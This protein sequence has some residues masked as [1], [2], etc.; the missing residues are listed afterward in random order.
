[1]EVRLNHYMLKLRLH[2]LADLRELCKQLMVRQNGKRDEVANRLVGYLL[3]PE[4]KREAKSKLP[5]EFYERFYDERESDKSSV[6]VDCLCDGSVAGQVIKCTR[7]NRNQHIM[8]IGKQTQSENYEC[9]SCQIIQMHPLDEVLEFLITPFWICKDSVSPCERSFECSF[10]FQ[11]RIFD[12]R[13]ELQ[14]QIRCIRLDG[15]GYTQKWPKHGSLSINGKNAMEFTV[16]K[17]PN[18]KQRKDEI[19]NISVLLANGKNTVGLLKYNDLDTYAAAVLL[20]KQK[21]EDTLIREITEKPGLSIEEG[22]EFVINKLARGDDD[23]VSE[24]VKLSLKC[25]FAMTFM[26]IPVRAVNCTH[27]QCFNLAT[28]VKLQ[29]ASRVNRWRCPICKGFAFN[30]IV[31]R[32]FES[33]IKTAMAEGTDMH[34]IEFFRD[35]SYKIITFDEYIADQE[36]DAIFKG[37]GPENVKAEDIENINRKRSR[38]EDEGVIPIKTPKIDGHNGSSSM[39]NGRSIEMIELD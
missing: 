26:E 34:N 9:V 11:Q 31:D 18:A 36:E 28:F 4:G 17:N 8:C 7:C 12:S 15:I 24:S 32:Y 1:M 16:S 14:V 2:K 39:K 27:I 37:S 6:Q 19:L 38:N 20:I 23:I 21:S 5:R 35:G 25:P 33:I 29:R 3:T 13:G 10:E 30:L 22:K